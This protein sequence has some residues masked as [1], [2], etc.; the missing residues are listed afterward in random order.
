MIGRIAMI[1]DYDAQSDTYAVTVLASATEVA[2][3]GLRDGDEV[4]VSKE[5]VP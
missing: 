4:V 3:S 5:V 2:D 1:G